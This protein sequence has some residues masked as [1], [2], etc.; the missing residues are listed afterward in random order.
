M[1]GGIII[2]TS[3]SIISTV[4]HEMQSCY[5]SNMLQVQ[6]FNNEKVINAVSAKKKNCWKNCTQNIVPGDQA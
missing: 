1:R 6:I 3:I 5:D 2:H 4:Y